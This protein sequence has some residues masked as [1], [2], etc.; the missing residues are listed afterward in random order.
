MAKVSLTSIPSVL[1]KAGTKFLWEIR[2]VISRE[3]LKTQSP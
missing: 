3:D 2:V 1:L